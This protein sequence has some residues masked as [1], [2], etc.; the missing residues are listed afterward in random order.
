MLVFGLPVL[1]MVCF[2]PL[3]IFLPGL[4][5]DVDL[6][7]FLIVSEFHKL[8]CFSCY[9][10]LLSFF[11]S[12]INFVYDIFP[13]TETL[14]FDMIKFIRFF[15]S[16]RLHFWSLLLEVFPHPQTTIPVIT[17]SVT[18]YTKFSSTKPFI[19]HTS[20]FWKWL[21][22]AK[23]SSF[24]V[25]CDTAARWCLGLESPPSLTGLAVDAGCRPEHKASPCTLGILTAC[26]WTQNARMPRE[27]SWSL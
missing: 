5:C 21:G 17:G 9:K 24:G 2:S 7:E 23:Q 3:C 16:K 25:S 14:I 1:S 26:N 6:Q 19:T 8:I 13:W 20:Q 11:L 10:Y 15:S 18:H 27:R 4:S 22:S 12:N